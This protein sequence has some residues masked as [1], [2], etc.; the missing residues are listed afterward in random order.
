M[1]ELRVALDNLITCTGRRREGNGTWVDI[2]ER[3][4]QRKLLTK[5]VFIDCHAQV[6][7]SYFGCH[8]RLDLELEKS[9]Q[10]YY[11]KSR[12][13]RRRQTNLAKRASRY[14]GITDVD[15]CLY[16]KRL[17]LTQ[18]KVTGETKPRDAIV[19]TIPFP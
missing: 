7:L 17:L 12:W 16:S 11:L 8:L 6:W 10:L 5:V 4:R 13:Q 1:P 15:E 2:W 18:K 14:K 9:H 19:R 3:V